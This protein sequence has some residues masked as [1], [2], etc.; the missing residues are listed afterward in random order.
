M[1]RR[2]ISSA[3][4]SASLFLVLFS[5]SVATTNYIA[6]GQKLPDQSIIVLSED[7]TNPGVVGRGIAEQKI[8]N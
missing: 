3:L 8:P 5:P 1:K 7:V 6:V 4:L 2:L